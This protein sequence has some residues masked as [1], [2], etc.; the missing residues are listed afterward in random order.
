MSV[1]SVCRQTWLRTSA[2]SYWSRCCLHPRYELRIIVWNTSGVVLEE[3]SITGDQ[4]SD[5]YVKGWG[6]NALAYWLGRGEGRRR[7]GGEGRREGAHRLTERGEDAY[8]LTERG[9]VFSSTERGRRGERWYQGDTVS[10]V[11]DRLCSLFTWITKSVTLI[12]LHQSN[13]EG[14]RLKFDIDDSC[15][16]S[17]LDRWNRREAEDGR[18]LQVRELLFQPEL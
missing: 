4:M 15:S 18:A 17:Q 14:W 2:P 7:G 8:R 16:N 6:W 10:T 12:T 9:V 5:I 11:M 3:T 13:I 1:W